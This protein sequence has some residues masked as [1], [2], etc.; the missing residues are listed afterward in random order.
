[1]CHQSKLRSLILEEF[2]LKGDFK[3]SSNRR[4]NLYFDIKSLSLSPASEILAS[5]IWDRIKGIEV[6]S[7][8][9]MATGAIPLISLI[10]NF[11][12]R[13][14]RRSI[15]G[16]YLRKDERLTGSIKEPILLIEDVIT[17]GNSIFKLINF[18]QNL[19]YQLALVLAVIDRRDHPK[20][21][22]FN[23]ESIFKFENGRLD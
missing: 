5:V 4:S 9:G 22:K 2:T 10:C 3:L 8:G 21:K 7:V 18:L 12:W 1:M 17:T 15:Q 23:F 11:A 20:E 16:F 13:T 14:E 19:G 6:N